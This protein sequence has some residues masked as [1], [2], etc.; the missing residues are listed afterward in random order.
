[1]EFLFQEREGVCTPAPHAAG[2]F[3]NIHGGAAAA[4]MASAALK[5]VPEGFTPVAQRTEFL[6]STPLSA[7][8]IELEPV[9]EGRTHIVYDIAIISTSSQ[10]RTAR[11]TITFYNPSPTDKIDPIPSK[12]WGGYADPNTLSNVP[13][14]PSPSGDAAWMISATDV[15]PDMQGTYWFRWRGPLL[16]NGWAHWFTKLLGPADWVGGFISPG[17]PMHTIGPWP[18]TDLTVQV[19]RPLEGEWIGLRPRGSYRHTGYGL[20]HSQLIDQE[21]VFG[22]ALASTI[23]P[24]RR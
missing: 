13:D 14:M 23:A 19:D 4:I 18:N 24:A 3:R 12:P 9:R 1:M 20:G 15:R 10:K 11:S 22:H 17:F 8:S 5:R 21:G 6:H 2:P 7:F 16:A